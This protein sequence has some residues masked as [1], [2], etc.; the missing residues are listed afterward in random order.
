[1][2]IIER[3]ESFKWNYKTLILKKERDLNEIF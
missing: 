1:M 3:L 2:V